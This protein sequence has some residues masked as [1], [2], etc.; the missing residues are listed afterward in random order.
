MKQ[1]IGWCVEGSKSGHISSV[2]ASDKLQMLSVFLNF[3]EIFREHL[4]LAASNWIRF[5]PDEL[6]MLSVFWNFL[7]FS[8]SIWSSQPPIGSDPI[9]SRWAPDPFQNA[10]DRFRMLPNASRCFRMLQNA[11]ECL[12]MPEN[13]SQLNASECFQM[14]QNASQYFRML[15]NASKCFKLLQNVSDR[16]QMLPNA[17]R[18]FQMLQ[19]APECFP[20]F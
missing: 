9:Q 4:E 5:D 7:K 18:C 1:E 16:F 8:E 17:S 3:F 11:S 12:R 15:E 14:P 2:W 19:N 20:C 10:S 6:Q 13:A